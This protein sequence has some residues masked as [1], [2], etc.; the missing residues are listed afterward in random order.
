M[1][2]HFTLLVD[3]L[4]FTVPASSVEE[5]IQVLG[6]DWEKAKAGF[7]GYPIC[8][9]RSDALRGVGKL[10][11]RAPRRPNEIHA[12]LSGGIVS[13]FTL[14]QIRHLLRWI[15]EKQGHLT[16]IDC[17]L[18]DRKNTVSMDTIRQAVDAGKCVTRAKTMRRFSSSPTHGPYAIT[19]ETIYLGSAQSE[20]LLR[21]YDKSLELKTKEHENWQDYGVRWELEFKKT[22]AQ[23]CGRALAYFDEPFWKEFVVGLLRSYVDFRETTREEDDE[24]RYRAPVTEWYAQLTEGFQKG[25]L[26][27]EK[28][29]QT[30]T[31]VK[32]WVS[33]S[34]SPMLAVIC[35]TPGGED[36]LQKEIAR[37][38]VR[39]KDRHRNLLNQKPKR[40]SS[41]PTGG[42]AGSP[43]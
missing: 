15:E 4:A 39:W 1:D 33:E 23:L 35:D 2:S 27:V 14:E 32:S 9:I 16:R 12:D 10:G 40:S 36:W 38:K 43:I 11:T 26:V 5:T 30:L 24:D 3:W 37:G 25:R 8:W 19:G 28:R 7:R 6:G 31:Q 21:I 22:R 34:L 29:E 18:D 41:T 42:H 17:A 20:T 13:K